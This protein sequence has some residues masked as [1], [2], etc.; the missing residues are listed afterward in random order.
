MW[1]TLLRATNQVGLA[2]KLTA[3]E[4]RPAKETLY[5]SSN[6]YADM[7]D[8]VVEDDAQVKSLTM[9]YTSIWE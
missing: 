5:P 1:F 9:S 3:F 8:S 6:G 4:V 7:V 2:K